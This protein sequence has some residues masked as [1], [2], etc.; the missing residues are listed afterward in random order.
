MNTTDL[1]RELTYQIRLGEDSTY[2]FKAVIIE[3][4]EK[5]FK[6]TAPNAVSLADEIAA[7]ANTSGGYL[8]LGVND[9]TRYIEGIA[10][11]QLGKLEEWLTSIVTDKIKLT[12]DSNPLGG[13]C[14]STGLSKSS[15][16][17][18]DS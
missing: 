4:D 11:E 9:K 12:L 13:D 17:G 3:P 1:V 10:P 18:T 5:K 6:V 16:L 2:E 14:G 15:D 7:F 8:V